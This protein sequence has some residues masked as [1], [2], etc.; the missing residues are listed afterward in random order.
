LSDRRRTKAGSRR[1]TATTSAGAGAK[2]RGPSA[3]ILLY[4]GDPGRHEVLLVHPGGPWW[5]RQEAGAWSIPK[6]ECMT[7]EEPY[8]AAR[9]EF[10]EELGVPPPDCDALQ[11]GEIRQRAGKRVLAWALPGDLDTTAVK[12]NT[13]NIEWPPHSGKF[14]DFPEVDRAEWFSVETAR[15]KINP[16]Q[17]ELLDRLEAALT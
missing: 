3:G 11:L 9:R 1:R 13:F 4:R 15:Q 7:D 12:S 17:V 5:R 14:R 6:G 2:L 8:L 10:V 16:A